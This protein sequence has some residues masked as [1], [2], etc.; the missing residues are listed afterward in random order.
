MFL[1]GT[2]NPAVIAEMRAGTMGL[3]R[4]P[5]N[6]YRLDEVA[7]WAMD[8]GCF[9]GT[10]PG[11]DKYMA[12]LDGL[13]EHQDRCLFVASPD[14]VGNAEVTLAQLP[15]MAIRIRAAGWPVALVGQDGMES[16]D[17]PWHLVD[18]LFVGGSTEWKLGSGAAE[19]IRRAHEAGKRVHV[20]RVNS[21]KRWKLFE[22]LGAESVDGTFIAFGPDANIV[23]LKRWM[24][25]DHHSGE[26]IPG[27]AG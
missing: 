18:W 22:G 3:L 6:G 19:L 2:K 4:T 5:G 12:I 23:R 13:I 20:G 24:A 17:V 25:D 1:S 15:A 14:V 26:R 21:R 8:N 9:K 16:M 11:D 27:T 10:Y 7:V